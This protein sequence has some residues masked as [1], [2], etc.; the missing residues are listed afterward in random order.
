MK[1]CAHFA[2]TE[3]VLRPTFEFIVAYKFNA[4]R[5]ELNLQHSTVLLK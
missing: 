2:I 5:V 1:K 3:N 4:R